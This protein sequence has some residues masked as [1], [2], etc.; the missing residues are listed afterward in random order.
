MQRKNHGYQP[1]TTFTI[2]VEC[3]QECRNM[4]RRLTRGLYSKTLI[5]TVGSPPPTPPSVSRVGQRPVGLASLRPKPL[6]RS[7]TWPPLRNLDRNSTKNHY[8]CVFPAFH[9]SYL[10]YLSCQPKLDIYCAWK[11]DVFSLVII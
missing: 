9:F 3:L 4:F 6:L 1:A 11:F 5:R 7:P 10:C 8:T 2:F